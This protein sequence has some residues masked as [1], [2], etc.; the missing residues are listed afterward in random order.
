MRNAFQA[1][2][3]LRC[4]FETPTVARL[5]E[6]IEATRQLDLAP[7]LASFVATWGSNGLD[8]ERL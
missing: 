3:P 7:S 4:S 1:E 5:A 2:L 8:E 6:R